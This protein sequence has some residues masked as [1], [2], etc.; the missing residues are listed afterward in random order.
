[1]DQLKLFLLL[2]MSI[3]P[4]LTPVAYLQKA[5]HEQV[6]GVEV[7][8]LDEAVHGLHAD[9]RQ[10]APVPVDVPADAGLQVLAD[11]VQLL[12]A[13]DG[14]V[15]QG[16]HLVLD[17][18]IAGVGGEDAVHVALER[19]TARGAAAQAVGHLLGGLGQVVEKIVT[20]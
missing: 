2:H 12:R 13:L 6:D 11:P 10:P 14:V 1:M 7:A 17:E 16:L 18:A 19:G 8:A 15:D 3:G 4:T 9:E 20:R 5:L